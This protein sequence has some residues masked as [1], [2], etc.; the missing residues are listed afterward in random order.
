MIVVLMG[1]TGSGKTT[2]GK[3][4]ATGLGW[5]FC[6]ADDLHPSQNVEKMRR[7]IPLTDADRVPW[8]EALRE[9]VRECVKRDE[10]A[11]IACSALKARYREYLLIDGDVKLVYLKGEMQLIEE[12]LGAR[13]GHFMNP[14]LL[15]SQFETLEE[16]QGGVTVVDIAPSPEAIVRT[17]RTKLGL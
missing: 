17:I 6:D 8:L 4:L 13:R 9:F 2:I 1:V 14:K 5:Q 11:V 7:G 16:P 12:R 10:S 3:L 15:Q